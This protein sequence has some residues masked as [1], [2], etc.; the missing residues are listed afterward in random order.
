MATKDDKLMPA[1]ATDPITML[2]RMVEQ[3]TNPEALSKMMDLADRWQAAEAKKKY[4]AA[5]LAFKKE[6]PT[7][8][9][10][11]P[12]RG[13]DKTDSS[14]AKIPKSGDVMYTFASY[15]DIKEITAPLERKHDITTSFDFEVTAAGNLVGTLLITVGSHTETRKFGCPVPKGINTNT[16]QEFGGAMTYLRRYLYTAAFDLV[17]AGE[18]KDGAGLAD[19]IEPEQIGELN[20]LVQACEKAGKPVN[21]GKFLEWLD[22]ETLDELTPAGFEKAKAELKRKAGVK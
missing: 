17:I 2:A 15:D 12:V 11:N 22:V 9:K 10:R 6:C 7:I 5:V 8:I 21:F 1:L 14:G 18:D 4:T 13:K 20:D 19:K 16:A 3:G